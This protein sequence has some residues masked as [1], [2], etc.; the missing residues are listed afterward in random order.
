MLEIKTESYPDPERQHARLLQA[1][2][3]LRPGADFH[4]LAL[5]PG[6]FEHVAELPRACWLPVARL[7]VE[8]MS[9]FALEQDCA[10]VA[11]PF[12]A[13]GRQRIARHHRQG[14]SVG[15]GFPTTR[16]LLH[17][18]LGRGIDWLFSNQALGL[19]RHSGRI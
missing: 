15:V 13:L 11:G 3:G 1:L 2:T 12:M 5:Q 9:A 18:E 6:L 19:L 10:G 8:Q 14:Q 16:R 17:R 7:N 4:I